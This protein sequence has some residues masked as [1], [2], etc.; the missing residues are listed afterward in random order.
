M[1]P[2]IGIIMLFSTQWGRNFIDTLSIRWL[3][4]V[5]I[6]RIPVEI[7]LLGL[8]LY[9]AIPRLMTFEGR[10][11]DIIAGISALAVYYFIFI[12]K[13]LPNKALL[14]WNFISLGL[15]LNIVINAVLSLPTAFQQ[16]GFDQPNVAILYFPFILLPSVIVP[17]VL[18]SHLVV[19][20]K[21]MKSIR[22]PGGLQA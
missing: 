11:F 12:K 16:F 10:N 1:P 22:K 13:S 17:L 20:R 14:F 5:H 15:L 9:K 6:V 3:T 7:T 4:L 2:V 21:L 8:Y 18:F 19:I